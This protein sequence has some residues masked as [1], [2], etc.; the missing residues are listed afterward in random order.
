MDLDYK[1]ESF[2]VHIRWRWTVITKQN[3]NLQPFIIHQTLLQPS[4]ILYLLGNFT[5]IDLHF[6]V[7]LYTP[8]V[9][10]VIVY[11]FDLYLKRNGQN[12]ALCVC[13]PF[14]MKVEPAPIQQDSTNHT[15]AVTQQVGTVWADTSG[16]NS[17]YR[18][19][20]TCSEIKGGK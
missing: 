16:M 7:L 10:W 2:N 6:C 18:K 3:R 5:V 19:D 17:L 11:A 9:F 15:Q 13:G 20:R 12:A 8:W 1:A 14:Y 4:P